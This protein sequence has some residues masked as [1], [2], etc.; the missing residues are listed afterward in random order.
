MNHEKAHVSPQVQHGIENPQPKVE[1]GRAP[2][3]GPHHLVLIVPGIRDRGG[4]WHVPKEEI[5]KAGFECIV[6]SWDEYFGVPRFLVPAPWFRRAAMA[7]LEARIQN[8]I[9][10]HT[11]SGTRQLPEVSF[12]AHSF[13]SYILCYL[14]RKKYHFKVSRLIICG[15]VLPGSFPFASFAT[16]V[17]SV[18][19]EVGNKDL[20][21]FI[22]SC[23]TFGYGTIGTYGYRNASVEDRFH[24][25]H[26]HGGFTE[27]G[28]AT[29]WW[30]PLLQASPNDPIQT[31]SPN[32]PRFEG[33]STRT[34]FAI[35]QKLKWGLVIWFLGYVG[36]I[37]AD[38]SVRYMPCEMQ[39]K[40][41]ITELS[42]DVTARLDR[43]FDMSGT[44]CVDGKRH[45]AF[46]YDDT[47][48]F[49][50][51]I[52]TYIV[53]AQIPK[54]AHVTFTTEG[55]KY[56]RPQPS[57]LLSSAGVD[58]WGKYSQVLVD[59]TLLH[60]R[61]ELSGDAERNDDI[62]GIAF[63]SALPLNSVRITVKL[64]Q[65]VTIQ[66]IDDRQPSL[67]EALKD[68]DCTFQYRGDFVHKPVLDCPK[69]IHNTPYIGN[70]LNWRWN[71]FEDC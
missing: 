29:R 62:W 14:L 58:L 39:R 31:P 36:L 2:R 5:R 26:G 67:W 4:D 71:A 35:A 13:G 45:Y 6:V 12:I 60:H 63:T 61:V 32:C 30:V 20:W 54:D 9:D 34:L 19:N 24:S 22:A 68:A 49:S 55:G 38:A 17:G 56:L 59:G 70:F 46:R 64:P 40:L 16:R 42:C 41:G 1:A 28:F 8:A 23:V 21:P 53:S 69:P 44:G 25:D 57:R 51:P 47:L 15:S 27:G 3:N 52:E 66:G 7:R 18:V 65:N 50:K 10:Q 37:G 11:D 48:T 33:S 43:T